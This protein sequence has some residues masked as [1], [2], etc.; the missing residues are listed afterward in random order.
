VP[1]RRFG[2][3]VA[4]VL[5]FVLG[6][7]SLPQSYVVEAAPP[8]AVE[9]QAQVEAA[10]APN[11]KRITVFGRRFSP[12]VMRVPIGT[13][14][15]WRNGD[16]VKHQIQGNTFRDKFGRL[17]DISGSTTSPLPAGPDLSNP[18]GMVP[19]PE[20]VYPGGPRPSELPE[21]YFSFT[22]P[23]EGTYSYRCTIHRNMGGLLVVG[24]PTTSIP[25]DPPPPPPPPPGPTPAPQTRATI[26]TIFGNRFRPEKVQ[27]VEGTT[28]VFRNGDRAAHRMKGSSYRDS[29]GVLKDWE[30]VRDPTNPLP[31]SG[32]APFQNN[33]DGRPTPVPGN[34]VRE[35]AG[36][37]TY[38]FTEPGTYNYRG[39]LP[40]MRGSV[41][42]V[43]PTPVR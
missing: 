25:G 24:S 8:S 12:A 21:S 2:W 36:Q 40:T 16:R 28:V 43:T 30:P 14:I 33:F 38:P 7:G 11:T 4:V 26:V 23:E 17:F 9:A 22:P 19:R 34:P 13:T 42:V 31:A 35:E 32:L 37:Y 39:E 41:V 27:V 15:E 3:A 20:P 1:G 10:L 5:A 18:A 6:V 29:L